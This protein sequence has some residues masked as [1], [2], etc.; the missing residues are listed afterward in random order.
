MCNLCVW[1]VIQ[2]QLAKEVGW[3]SN[4]EQAAA[5]REEHYRV[6]AAQQS[7][8]AGLGEA[9]GASSSANSTAGASTA[10][11]NN[12]PTKTRGQS[13][14]STSMAAGASTTSATSAVRGNSAGRRQPTS[15]SASTTS[16]SNAATQQVRLDVANLDCVVPLVL[17]WSTAV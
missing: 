10:P 8:L 17:T 13:P 11:E 4:D 5:V 7:S 15:T 2:L 16:N 3:L 12:R 1:W 14:N 9:A 6:M